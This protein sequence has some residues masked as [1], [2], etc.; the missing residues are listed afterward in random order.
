[1]LL[2]RRLAGEFRLC[3][4]VN[5][6]RWLW[7]SGWPHARARRFGLAACAG[8]TI[9]DKMPAYVGQPASVLITKLG[10]PTR[11]DSVAGQ[12]VY[13]WTTGQVVEGT[14]YACTIR[15]ILDSQN[16]VTPTGIIK[17]TRA[18][19]PCMRPFWADSGQRRQIGLG[20]HA[21]RTL[22]FTSSRRLAGIYPPITP[23]RQMCLLANAGFLA[24]GLARE[25]PPP[26]GMI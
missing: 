4:G 14:S 22:L 3:V 19:A 7:P 23:Y 15:A 12:T 11:Q 5:V 17:V 21:S 16:V 25:A 26:A 2:L 13:V 9:K 20:G 8:Q 10:F 1:M 6:R 18:V 24:R